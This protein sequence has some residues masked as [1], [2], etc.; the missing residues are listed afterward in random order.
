MLSVDPQSHKSGKWCGQTNSLR[1]LDLVQSPVNV[2]ILAFLVVGKLLSGYPFQLV[3]KLFRHVAS[4][5]LATLPV[6]AL[7]W[8]GA[9]W[10]SV[11]IV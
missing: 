1:S 2:T 7:L 9:A 8:L 6:C 5:K 10:L 11:R 3:L 4:A